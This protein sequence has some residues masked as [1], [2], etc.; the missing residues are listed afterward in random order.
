MDHRGMGCGVGTR[1]N[2]I[3]INLKAGFCERMYE[4]LGFIKVEKLYTSETV[5]IS[6]TMF[7]R[8]YHK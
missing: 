1:I 4:S 2:W 7:Y 5:N 6:D 8:W 3:R